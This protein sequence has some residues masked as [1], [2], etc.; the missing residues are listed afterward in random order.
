[1]TR[2]RIGAWTWERFT[3]IRTEK[4]KKAV[5]TEEKFVMEGHEKFD[6]LAKDGAEEDSVVMDAAKAPVEEI[7]LCVNC[8]AAPFQDQVEEWKDRDEGVPTEKEMWKVV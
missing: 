8:I 1:M 4:E 6:E 2:K 5:T 3:A 7:K